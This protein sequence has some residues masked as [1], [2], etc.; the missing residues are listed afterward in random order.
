MKS[1]VD[2]LHPVA[3]AAACAVLPSLFLPSPVRAQSA[4]T[5]QL[6]ENVVTATRTSQ[7]IGDVVADV[8]IIDRETIERSGAVGL[9]DIL[10]RVPGFQFTRN[11]GIGNSTNVFVRGGESRHTPVLIDGVR[12]ESQTISG[13]AS[14]SSIPISQ[15]DRIEI[16]RGPTSAVYGSDA[17]AGMIQIFT[18]KGQGAFSPLVTVGYGSYNT[19]R[20]DLAASGAVGAVDYSVGLSE[21][22][23]DGFNVRPIAGQNPDADGYK[24]HGANARIGWQL[25][26]NHRLEANILQNHMDAQYDSG[27]TRD[28]RRISDLQ[29]LGLAW[30]AQWSDRYSTRLSLSQGMDST[31]EGANGSSPTLSYDKS[32]ISALLLQNEYRIG[33]HLL[34]ATLESRRD[35]F[36][37]VGSAAVPTGSSAIQRSRSL[38]GVALGYGWSAGAHTVQFNARHDNDSEF[39]G[40]S[41]GSA[42]YAYAITPAWKASASA[43][44]SFRVPTLYQ[45]FSIYGV[46]TLR[47]ESGRNVEVALKYTQGASQYGVTAYRNRVSDLLTFVSGNGPCTNGGPPTT[48]ANRGC[49]ANTA[50]A[51]YT[52]LTFTAAE[53]IGNVY[54]HASLDLQ[55]PKNLATNRTLP[56]RSRQ[57]GTFGAETRVGNWTVASDVLMASHTQDSDSSNVILPGYTLVNLSA[58]T[59]LGRDWKLIAKLDNLTD[60]NYQTASTY[61]SAR[62]TLYV[63]LTWA[64]Q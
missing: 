5:P 32:T 30:Q 17:V 13:G 33:A 12:V 39:G 31:E 24:S 49:Y 51:Q 8:T 27:L 1:C 60:K 63:G 57:Y 41:T 34:S 26:A 21:G 48:V 64:P 15:I 11:G 56:R 62:R 23:S 18:K 40:K 43:G 52:G 42:A 55:N 35:R 47:P 6:K 36:T 25:H 2:R 44:T 19:R 46:P 29:T 22:S 38:D 10:A 4:P 16:V 7:P 45:R 50:L 9:A 37:L 14:W 20:V 61:A 54:L 3:L 28:Y 53:T 58:A 59:P